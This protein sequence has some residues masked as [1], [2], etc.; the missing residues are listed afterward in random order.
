[1]TRLRAPSWLSAVDLIN[2][3]GLN[4]SKQLVLGLWLHGK[5]SHFKTFVKDRTGF[6]RKV[7]K[8][9]VES[10]FHNSF[11][12]SSSNWNVVNCIAAD[13]SLFFPSFQLTFR[14]NAIN[15]TALNWSAG[16]EGAPCYVSR[17]TAS[18]LVRFNKCG[19]LC[20]MYSTSSYE[21]VINY[22]K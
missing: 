19:Q 10:T 17:A 1:M 13:Q 11:I 16:A 14:S 18:E 3:S 7:E 2:R 15:V 4:R 21:T 22:P 9:S 5:L 12:T 6:A 20:I 8:L